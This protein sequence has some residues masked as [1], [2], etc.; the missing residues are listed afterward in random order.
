M[1]QAAKRGRTY[2]NGDFVYVER[3]GQGVQEGRITGVGEKY[4][5]LLSNGEQATVNHTQLW[6]QPDF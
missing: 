4:D 1:S 5:V 3:P 2:S 6:K